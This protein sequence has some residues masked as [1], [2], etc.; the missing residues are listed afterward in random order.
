MAASDA[1]AGFTAR[2]HLVRSADPHRSRRRDILRR[3][4]EVRSLMGSNP[5]TA[6]LTLGLAAA[7]LGLAWLLRDAPFWALLG[8]AY[9]VGT[10]LTA[11]L[12][13]MIHEAAH[14]LIFRSPA[15]NHLAG[16]V[17]NLPTVLLSAEPF[18]R[19]HYWHHRALGD[20]AMDVG[21]PTEWEARWVGNSSWRKAVWL[22]GF[23]IFQWVRTFKF[24]G[25]RPFWSG[26]MVANL[27]VQVACNAAILW[28]W[29]PWPLVYLFLC[30]SFAFGFHPLGT[31]VIQEHFVVEDGQETNNYAGMTKAIECN[32]GYHVEHHD[33]PGIPWNRLPRVSELAPEFYQP[34]FEFPSRVRLMIEFIA[35]PRWHVYRNTIRLAKA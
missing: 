25:D 12:Y 9:A 7:Q 3:H 27:L 4:A 5:A 6:L 13:A 17:A 11:A 32:F 18:R 14:G 34:L 28:F 1:A 30:F 33:F 26:W 35:D 19:Y 24:P 8:T 29:G 20:Y 22:A 2:F 21:V 15:G 16:L 31:R 10:F 23:P